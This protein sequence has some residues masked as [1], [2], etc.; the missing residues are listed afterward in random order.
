M[1]NSESVVNCLHEEINDNDESEDD[2]EGDDIDNDQI[3][4]IIE[5]AITYLSDRKVDMICIPQE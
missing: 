3:D 2:E 5:L 4:N 1:I